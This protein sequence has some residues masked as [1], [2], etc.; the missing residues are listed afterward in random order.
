[1][2]N[3][4]VNYIFACFKKNAGVVDFRSFLKS[5][6]ETKQI[7]KAQLILRNENQ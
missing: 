1:L 2:V 3:P 4:K 7:E 6:Y 5:F